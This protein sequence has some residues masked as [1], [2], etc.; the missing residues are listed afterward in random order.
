MHLKLG[1]VTVAS[2]GPHLL[3]ARRRRSK[4]EVQ[5]L[6]SQ[7]WGRREHGL[8]AEGPFTSGRVAAGWLAGWLTYETDAYFG[9]LLHLIR[10]Q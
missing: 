3:M 8:R 2:S 6:M 9:V 10:T 5:H 1:A 7:I 4:W